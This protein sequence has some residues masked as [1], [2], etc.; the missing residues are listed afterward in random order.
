M[1]PV[2]QEG[3]RRGGRPNAIATTL[4][5]LLGAYWLIGGSVVGVLALGYRSNVWPL[6]G[7]VLL[8]GLY[9]VGGYALPRR[10]LGVRWWGSLLCLLSAAITLVTRTEVPFAVEMNVL[11]LVLVLVSWGWWP[12]PAASRGSV[13]RY[14][15]A[16]RVLC[17]CAA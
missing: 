15:Q 2:V 3:R 9:G 1:E 13:D 12:A 14:A 6:L 16:T 17:C 4:F 10:R 7:A 5:W 11:A 8:G